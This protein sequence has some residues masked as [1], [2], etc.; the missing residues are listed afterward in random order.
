MYIH[1]SIFIY[2]FTYRGAPELTA[3]RAKSMRMPRA[4]HTFWRATDACGHTSSR[5]E[6][7]GSLFSLRKWASSKGPAWRC[8]LTSFLPRLA[9]TGSTSISTPPAPI[10]TFWAAGVPL[11]RTTPFC[12]RW[13]SCWTTGLLLWASLSAFSVLVIHTHNREMLG[14]VAQGAKFVFVVDDGLHT[15]EALVATFASFYEHLAD[16]FLYVIY[17]F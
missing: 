6:G 1:E 9:S 14:S 4:M 17:L 10:W 13:T 8:G 3:C 15:E 7:E 12:M 16:G 2:I 11:R 5:R